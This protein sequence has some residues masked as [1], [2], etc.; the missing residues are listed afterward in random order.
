[1]ARSEVA[2][3][4][5]RRAYEIAYV[6]AALHGLGI[7]AAVAVLGFAIYEAARSFWLFSGAL[8]VTLAILAWRGGAW[9]RG[10]FAGVLAGLPP[11]L[12][13][14]VVFVLQNTHCSGCSPVTWPCAIACFAASSLVGIAVGY[15]ANHDA[16]PS[17]FAAG[18][19]TTAALTGL[20]GCGTIGLGGAIG[21]VIG[22]IAGGATGWLVAGSAPRSAGA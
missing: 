9:R 8:A 19:L 18:A 2:L 3:R 7:A 4:R 10:G 13:P 21:V 17:R 12:V 22:L 16:G 15:R 20:I 5:A 11:L 1:M 14:N 6:T